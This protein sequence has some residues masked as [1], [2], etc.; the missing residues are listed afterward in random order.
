M[1]SC[2]L[3]LI[4]SA[5]FLTYLPHASAK[6]LSMT[7]ELKRQGDYIVMLPST[8]RIK[9][10]QAYSFRVIN[11]TQKP[12]CL[13]IP[14]EPARMIHPGETITWNNAFALVDQFDLS[15]GDNTWQAWL[16][17]E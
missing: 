6:A 12:Q 1:R 15:C 11:K 10:G 5:C 3:V 9:H 4:A 13:Q 7:W 8:V 2:L 16:F 17:I 14:N